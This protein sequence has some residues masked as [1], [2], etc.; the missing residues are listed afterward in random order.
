MLDSRDAETAT[1][2]DHPGSQPSRR[3]RPGDSRTFENDLFRQ[4][5]KGNDYPEHHEERDGPDVVTKVEKECGKK[6]SDKKAGQITVEG[7]A[8]CETF[9]FAGR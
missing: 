4:G 2:T 7:Q 3:S 8:D 6:A 9:A 5:E 1:R